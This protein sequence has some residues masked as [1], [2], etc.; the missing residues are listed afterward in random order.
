VVVLVVERV[1][2]QVVEVVALV[3]LHGQLMVVLVVMEM[4]QHISLV[5]HLQLQRIQHPLLMD[6]VVIVEIV[7]RLQVA[8]AVVQEVMVVI[9]LVLL[10]AVSVVKDLEVLIFMDLLYLNL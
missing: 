9:S 4:L 7:D 3:L 10:L 5:L 1:R 6:G 2:H 8:V